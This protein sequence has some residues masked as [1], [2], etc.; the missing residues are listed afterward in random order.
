MSF[1]NFSSGVKLNNIKAYSGVNTANNEAFKKQVYSDIEEIDYGSYEEID[2]NAIDLQKGIEAEKNEKEWYE[3]AGATACVTATSIVSGVLKI[4][5]AASDG[6]T[7]LGGMAVSGVARL[8]GQKKFAEKFE[9]M[10]MDEIARD[11]VGEMNEFFYENTELGKAIN[12]ASALKYD[13]ELAQGIQNVT[14][15]AVIIAGATAATVVTGGA[16][17]P[18]FAAGFVVGA[19]QSA[20]KNY[21]DVENRD[22]WKDSAEIAVDGTIKGLSTMAYGKAGATAVNG[23]KSLGKLGL[24]GAKEIGKQA[25]GSISKES[26]KQTAKQSGKIALKTAGQTLIDKD[27]WLE[28]GGVLLDDVKSGMETGEWNVLKMVGD[29]ALIYG[30]NYIGNLAGNV[31]G[32]V[33]SGTKTE[34]NNINPKPMIDSNYD[35]YSYYD[36]T[37]TSYGV[38]QAAI[39]KLCVY[40]YNGQRLSYSQAQ[41]LVNQ[42]INN[43]Q[44]IPIISKKGTQEYFDLKNK[45]ISQGFSKTDASVIMSCVDDAGACSYASACNEIF[46]KFREN[47]QAFERTFGYPMYKNINGTQTLNSAELLLDLYVYSNDTANGGWL[48][49]QGQLNPNCLSNKIDSLGRM[50]PNAGD[51]QQYMSDWYFGS[52]GSYQKGRN[53]TAIDGFLKSKDQKLQFTSEVF[54]DN[55]IKYGYTEQDFNN[56]MSYLETEISNGKSASMT[57]TYVPSN[58]DPII[59]ML[60]YDT[61]NYPNMSTA[62]WNEGTAEGGAHSVAITGIA[63]TGLVVSSWGNKYMIPFDD[64]R[65]GGN[66]VITTSNINGIT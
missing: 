38:D 32:D 4:S 63:P 31:V 15:E 1:N 2:Y 23:V 62:S 45:L 47:P 17:A 51:Y 53:V 40:E 64:L 61:N 27:T 35:M 66:F 12:D 55:T 21:Q 14:T 18:L 26:L 11:K 7:W 36:N 48:I 41:D 13:S 57:Y 44:P 29:A 56:I 33:L 20:E 46:Y 49:H 19:G 6:L 24:S 39:K 37:G 9:E 22:F 3:V 25:L 59:N 65:N 43:G 28:T 58:G 5:E 54:M 8:F 50:M 34:T 30:E 16:A 42:A 52:D 10:T 60:S